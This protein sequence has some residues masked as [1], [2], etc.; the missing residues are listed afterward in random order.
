MAAGTLTYKN[1]VDR[2]KTAIYTSPGTAQ[3]TESELFIN[4]AYLLA[5]GLAAWSF[6]LSTGTTVTIS[7]EADSGNLPADYDRM[8][9]EPVL[10]TTDSYP[11][12]PRLSFRDSD[13][14]NA[15]NV[16]LAGR[17]A[18]PMYYSVQPVTWVA[19][20]GQAWE[21]VVTPT[22]YQDEKVQIRYIQLVTTLSANGDNLRGEPLFALAVLDAAFMLW[23]QRTQK[24]KGVMY[25][26]FYGTGATKGS[27]QRAIDKDEQRMPKILGETPIWRARGRPPHDVSYTIPS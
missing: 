21:I 9:L 25:D 6:L 7:A 1:L 15:E 13:F 4:D 16:R 5:S 3:T 2:L 19:A 22:P 11:S 24:A 12:M 10:I 14:V 17:T 20:T 26:A 27:L 23:E 8:Y 18:T